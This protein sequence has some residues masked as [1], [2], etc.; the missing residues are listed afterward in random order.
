[1]TP[2]AQLSRTKNDTVLENYGKCD[3]LILQYN[4]GRLPLNPG[5]TMEQTLEVRGEDVYNYHS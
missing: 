1:M 3:E 5:C 4:K 2:S